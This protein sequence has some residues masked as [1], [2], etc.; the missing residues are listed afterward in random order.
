[1]VRTVCF[2]L[3]PQPIL[4]HNTHARARHVPVLWVDSVSAKAHTL[5]VRLRS[6]RAR[7]PEKC[8]AL[9]PFKLCVAVVQVAKTRG[10]WVCLR[11][12]DSAFID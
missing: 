8:R 11:W 2:A 9:L 7:L 10:V 1:M 4:K 6:R 5:A 3:P 12:H